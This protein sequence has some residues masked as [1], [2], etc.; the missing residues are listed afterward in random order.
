LTIIRDLDFFREN[1]KKDTPKYPKV[2]A[3]Y[4]LAP[5]CSKSDKVAPKLPKCNKKV[6]YFLYS[7]N[8]LIILTDKIIVK[9][10]NNF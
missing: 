2:A 3:V 7:Y 9:K 10:I 4:N 1:Y 5:Q 6:T 8:T